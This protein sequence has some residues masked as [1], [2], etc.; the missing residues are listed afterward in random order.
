MIENLSIDWNTVAFILL[1]AFGAS[2]ALSAI[3]LGWVIWRVRKIK[4][5][6]DADFV[7]ALRAT[8]L[9]V[10]ILLDLLD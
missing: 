3:L 7:V 5:P 4:L 10:V 1:F 6:P 8:P 9:V 2:L